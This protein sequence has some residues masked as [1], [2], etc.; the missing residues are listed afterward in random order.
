MQKI[1]IA[2]VITLIVIAGVTDQAFPMGKR[3]PAKK[4]FVE[5]YPQDSE[6]I[7]RVVRVDTGRPAIIISTEEYKSLI[8][9]V[10]LKT[11]L[12]KDGKNIKLSEIKKGNLVKVDYEIVYKD[13]NIAKSINVE[14]SSM[15]E[16]KRK[17]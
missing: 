6:A 17:R 10:D 13:K 11:K 1:V 8:L 4:Y 15:F 14:S 16:P 12:L 2:S 3:P 9:I 5:R 7:G